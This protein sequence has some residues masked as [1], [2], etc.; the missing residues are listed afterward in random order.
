MSIKTN[1]KY[2]EELILKDKKNSL[3]YLHN[4]MINLKFI[5][6]GKP[7]SLFIGGKLDKE[8]QNK[9]ANEKN[10]KQREKENNN[11]NINNIF[12]KTF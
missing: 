4:G 10:N 3:E 8:K 9:I 7:L 2:W 12:S 5:P 6:Q 11:N 1:K